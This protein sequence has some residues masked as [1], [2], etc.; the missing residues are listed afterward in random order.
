M[1]VEI[2]EEDLLGLRHADLARGFLDA[3]L[4]LGDP[5]GGDHRPGG[6]AGVRVRREGAAP[7][8][9]EDGEGERRDGAQGEEQAGH[10]RPRSRGQGSRCIRR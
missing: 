5:F 7:G 3:G 6:L 2:A 4:A 10:G 8:D 9:V 1:H